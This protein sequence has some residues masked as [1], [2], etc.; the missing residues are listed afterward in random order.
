[1]IAAYFATLS[2]AIN[3]RSQ[4]IELLISNEFGK[5]WREATTKLV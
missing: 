3:V 2:A 1:M 5:M 4:R